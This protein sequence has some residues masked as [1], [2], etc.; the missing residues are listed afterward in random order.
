M[1]IQ[2]QQPAANDQQPAPQPQAPPSPGGAV[3]QQQNK[4]SSNLS[5]AD[6]QALLAIHNLQS[7]GNL[8]QKH[9]SHI[10]LLVTVITVVILALFASYMLNS[11]KPGTNAKTS[12]AGMVQPNGGSTNNT[13]NQINQDVHSCSNVSTAVSEC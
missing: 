5:D 13:T 11:L 9:K 12:N 2:G 10:G 8:G 7:S 3:P 4:S 6:A 1:E